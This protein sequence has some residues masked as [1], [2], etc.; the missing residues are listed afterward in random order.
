MF[1]HVL[2]FLKRAFSRKQARVPM[3]REDAEA[4]ARAAK[5][6]AELR[7]GPRRIGPG[8]RSIFK[9]HERLARPSRYMPHQGAREKARRLSHQYKK[10]LPP[11][12]FH[13]FPHRLSD[14]INADQP[15]LAA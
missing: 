2:K 6:N 1:Q 8:K 9:I 10:P 3:T 15:S 5:A 4:M 11:L 12:E 7:R 14:A 13:N